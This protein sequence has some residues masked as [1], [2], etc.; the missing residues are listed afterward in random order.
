MDTIAGLETVDINGHEM[1]PMASQETV[2]T[3]T[4]KK[5]YPVDGLETVDIIIRPEMDPVVCLE[6]VDTITGTKVYPHWPSGDCGH[7]NPSGNGPGLKTL[8]AITGTEM[9]ANTTCLPIFQSSAINS[10]TTRHSGS[11]QCF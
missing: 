8:S 2:D 6:T 3:I 9:T 4:G 1:D 10:I 7:H 5:V 11:K